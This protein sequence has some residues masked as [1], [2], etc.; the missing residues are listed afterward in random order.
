KRALENS[1][2]INRLKSFDPFRV[3]PI[4]QSSIPAQSR[5]ERQRSVRAY[6]LL[7]VTLCVFFSLAGC[8]ARRTPNLERIFMEARARTGKRPLI[9]IP[10]ILGSQLVNYETG[11]EVWPSIFRSANDGLSLPVSPD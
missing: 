3:K 4:L 8:G 7:L 9:I 1:L 6:V 11:E 5:Y 10:G 2:R